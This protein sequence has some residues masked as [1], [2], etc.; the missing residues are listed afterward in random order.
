MAYSTVRQQVLAFG[1]HD[2]ELSTDGLLAFTGRSWSWVTGWPGPGIPYPPPRLEH[3]MVYDL[4]RNRL[5]V[6]AGLTGAKYNGTWRQ[7]N[8]T[9]P[10]MQASWRTTGAS[11]SRSAVP[12]L[13]STAIP[14]L[15]TT[16]PINLTNLPATP[17]VAYLAFGF[18]DRATLRPYGMPDG[19]FFGVLPF[20]WV[21]VA[22]PGTST[23]Y[24]LV[25][26]NDLRL[27]GMQTLTQALM[28]G[29]P[30]PVTDLSNVGY[31][32]FY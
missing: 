4:W 11:C 15:G 3:A 32:L 23:T 19:C 2:D 30:G 10:T 9:P 21:A 29:L 28:L 12:V 31:M 1:G 5:I 26:P 6:T 17:G 20:A 24:G 14:Y 7:L 22:H 8:A 18:P 16:F 25:I 13:N 27:A